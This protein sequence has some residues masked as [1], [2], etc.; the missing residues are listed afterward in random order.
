[1]LTLETRHF[2]WM[3][4]VV[5]WCFISYSTAFGG[6]SNSITIFGESAGSASVS[7]HILSKMS[8]GLF[9]QAIMQVRLASS[10]IPFEKSSLFSYFLKNLLKRSVEFLKDLA[11]RRA[12]FFW[13]TM[14]RNLVVAVA[15]TTNWSFFFRVSKWPPFECDDFTELCTR[16][17]ARP[18]FLS[19]YHECRIW[20]IV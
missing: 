12:L 4:E 3:H 19:V 1:M 7:F 2:V 18:A 17:Q 9:S 13:W 14:T 20:F 6:D 16:L 5:I 10:N 11:K 15:I 8:E